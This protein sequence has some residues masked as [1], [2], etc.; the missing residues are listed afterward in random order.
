MTPRRKGFILAAAL[1]ALI[2]GVALRVDTVKTQWD[3]KV[4]MECSRAL[5]SGGD[6]YTTYPLFNGDHFQCLY[7]PLIIDLYRPF[8]FISDKLKGDEG[9]RLWAVLK[10][11]SMV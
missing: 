7:P 1:I 2:V 6:P 5:A 9:E 4:Y 8:T 3:L 11:L 10:V